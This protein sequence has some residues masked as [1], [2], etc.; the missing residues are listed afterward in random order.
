ML[1]FPLPSSFSLPPPPFDACHTQ[2]IISNL[3]GPL[4]ETTSVTVFL[5]SGIEIMIFARMRLPKCT[6]VN[7]H[8]LKTQ[9]HLV[10]ETKAGKRRFAFYFLT[11]IDSP[12]VSGR[13]F[14][15]W[16][17]EIL[18]HL[19]SSF[20]SSGACVLRTCFS[21]ASFVKD[22]RPQSTLG[23]TLLFSCKTKFDSYWEKKMKK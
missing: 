8:L 18:T 4:T 23:D 9:A 13:S 15:L 21:L 3:Y 19:I 2:A 16:T 20:S 14:K 17:K 1:P 22:V 10:R 12:Q 11:I 5:S 7:S 6:S